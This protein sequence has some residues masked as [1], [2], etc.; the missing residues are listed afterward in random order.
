MHIDFYFDE[1]FHDRKITIKS[2]GTINTFRDDANDSYIGVF[3]GVENTKKNSLK[4][5]LHSLEDEYSKRYGLEKEFKSTIIDKKSFHYGIRSFNKNSFDFYTDFF[6][7][8]EVTSPIIHVNALSKTEW[9]L[10]NIFDRNELVKMAVSS[11]SFYYS[12][13]K[14]ILFYH[15]EKL[16]HKMY[17]STIR[18]DA[19]LF[20]EAL[21]NQL[22]KVIEATEG[23]A[24]KQREISALKILY[25]I[26]K[27]YEFLHTIEEKYD[28]IYFQN[29]DG[30]IKLLNEKSI[31]IK[32]INLVIDN[33]EKTYSAAMKYSFNKIKQT[34]SK[35]CIQIR[36]VDHL[37]GFI[38]RMAFALINDEAMKEDKIVDVNHI[39]ENDLVRKRLL[40]TKWFDLEEKYYTLYCSIYKVLVVQQQAFWSAMTW[41]YGDQIVMFYSLLN[42]IG[43]FRSY[44]CF[45]KITPQQHVENYNFHC[46]KKLDEKYRTF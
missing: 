10:R 42:Y 40:N 1:T 3:L 21:L 33:E 39:A 20:K 22:Q 7:I 5:R 35:N 18:K 13:T 8:L 17:E 45:K 41:C 25:Q 37:C 38:G 32:K 46:C 24:R 11:D 23:I 9:L 29:F 16:I 19:G 26:I 43:S 34:D 27:S 4:K 2:N 36:A 30:L 44:E 28:F 6:K 15:D 12:L 31:S 14:F